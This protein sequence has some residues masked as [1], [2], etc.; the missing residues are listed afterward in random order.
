MKAE[1]LLKTPITTYELQE[2]KH[3]WVRV[4]QLVSF[5]KEYALLSKGEPLPG[6][7]RLARLTPFM[8]S[9]QLL[10]LGGRLQASLLPLDTKHPF[11]L[12]K[13]SPFT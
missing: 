9:Q 2:A 1:S 4:T 12:P 8:D 3:Y 7:H 13:E 6:N 11:I 10:R 5:N